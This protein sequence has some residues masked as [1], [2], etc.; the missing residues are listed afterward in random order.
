ME[1]GGTIFSLLALISRNAQRFLRLLELTLILLQVTKGI[2][3]L[4]CL[5]Q[6]YGIISDTNAGI[7]MKAL[8]NLKRGMNAPFIELVGFDQVNQQQ[9]DF[10]KL[11]AI[12]LSKTDL[13]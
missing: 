4:E 9:A 2:D 5:N 8:E 11:R 3:I 13:R 7:D 6:R 1:Q 10:S 12:D